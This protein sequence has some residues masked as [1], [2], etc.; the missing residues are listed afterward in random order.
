MKTKFLF[1]HRFK[2]IG[3]ILFVPAFI[4]GLYS[5]VSNKNMATINCKVFAIFS[6][7]EKGSF[8]LT[9]ANIFTEII[10]VLLICGGLLIA[11]SK[12]KDEDEYIARIRLESLVWAT[13]VNYAL[14]LFAFIFIYGLPFLDV[15]DINMFTI[16]IFFII[17]FHY[18][19]LKSRKV[20][21][22]EEQA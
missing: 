17:R 10:A 13:Y 3:W 2:I 22:H 6:D 19:L 18:F 16:L 15:M 4:L 14:L 1:P 11:F 12:V 7:S 5:I 9:D 8:A 20:L 21:K